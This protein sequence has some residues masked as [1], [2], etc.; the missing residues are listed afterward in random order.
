MKQGVDRLTI[1][2]LAAE[3]DIDPRSAA[4]ALRDGPESLRGRVGEKA[5]NAMARLGLEHE[6][7]AAKRASRLARYASRLS[8]RGR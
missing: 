4:K 1:L 3:A 5:A 8:G 2:R 7:E 6:K